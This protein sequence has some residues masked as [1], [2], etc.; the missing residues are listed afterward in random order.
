MTKKF[1]LLFLLLSAC[2]GSFDPSGERIEGLGETLDTQGPKVV[3]DVLARPLPEV[4]LPNDVAMRLDP[5]APTGRRVNISLETATQYERR[6]RQEFNRFDGFGTYAP[7]TVSFDAPLDLDNLESRHQDSDFRNDAVYLI[8][9]SPSCKRFGEEVYLDMGSGRFP[10]THYGR[11]RLKYDEQAPDGYRF[12]GKNPFFDF[13]PQAA[14]KN[15]L[16]AQENEDIDGDGR[17]SPSEDLDSDGHLDIANFKD[18]TA[19]DDST[20]MNCANRCDSDE[21][22]QTCL[23]EHDQCVADNLLTYYERETNTLIL[24]PIWP[25]EQ[26]CRYAVVLT[27]RL[28]GEK[29]KPVVSPFA[30]KHHRDQA[31]A[32]SVLP[33]LMSKYEIKASDIQF[34]WVFTTGSMT[35]DIEAIRAGLYGHGPFAMLEKAYPPVWNLWSIPEDESDSAT[36]P[37]YFRDGACSASSMAVLWNLGIGEFEPNLCAI[38]A[39]SSTFGGLF[40]GTFSTPNLLQDRE[41]IAT[42]EYPSDHDEV[43]QVDHKSGTIEHGPSEVSFWCALPKKAADCTPGNPEKKQFCPPFPTAIFAHGYGGSRLGARE[44]LGRHTAMGTAICSINGPWARQ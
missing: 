6:T 36:E 8:N 20:P 4:P 23:V 5:S 10:A 39:D 41:G 17:L 44:H 18:P 40:G 9:V 19:C 16:F 2:N 35:K 29:G 24:R 3:F 28:K 30:L 32:L 37:R 1:S 34:A 43:W 11:A 31:K 15:L 12:D 7:L 38:E 14:A 21:C 25:L 22:F 33:K 27:N 42:P 13:D 26:Q